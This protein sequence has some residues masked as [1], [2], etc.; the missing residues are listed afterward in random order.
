MS[1]SLVQSKERPSAE[2]WLREAGADP[3]AERIGMYLTHTGIVRKTAKAKVRFGDEGARDVSGMKIASDE[4]KIV[5]AI[6][7][8]YDLPGI[9]YIRVW[10][11]E[12]Q[13]ALGDAVMQVLIGG[14]IRPHVI[15]GLQFLVG[16]LKTECI[17][18]EELYPIPQDI[19][20]DQ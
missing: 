13:L 3:S 9:Y 1:R 12:G 19:A 6:G 17:T 20:S 4:K 11:N 2:D 7:E 16:K 8:A 14:D 18:E 15:D 5:A 10:V